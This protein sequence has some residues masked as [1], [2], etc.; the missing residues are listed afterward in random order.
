MKHLGFN[1]VIAALVLTATINMVYRYNNLS[2]VDPATTSVSQNALDLLLIY[3]PACDNVDLLKAYASDGVITIDEGNSLV[4]ICEHNTMQKA[5]PLQRGQ[6]KLEL[7]HRV[8]GG[9]RI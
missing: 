8:D 2:P 5:T 6:R 7:K 3:A 9:V 1:L 4:D